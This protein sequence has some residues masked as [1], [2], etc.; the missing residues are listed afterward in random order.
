MATPQN[1][2]WSSKRIPFYR[3]QWTKSALFRALAA[4]QPMQPVHREQKLP[5]DEK[6]KNRPVTR[7]SGSFS[8]L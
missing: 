6:S 7:Q 8:Y 3:E 1:S 5:A 4:A 2:P